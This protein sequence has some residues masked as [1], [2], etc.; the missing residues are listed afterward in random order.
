MY[1]NTLSTDDFSLHALYPGFRDSLTDGSRC[2]SSQ[3]A[4]DLE[5]FACRRRLRA[6]SAK[7]G[8]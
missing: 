8:L 4:Q 6:V 3:R 7:N 5:G 1:R 2:L